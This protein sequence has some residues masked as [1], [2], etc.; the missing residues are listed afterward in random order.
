MQEEDLDSQNGSATVMLFLGSLPA[1][2]RAKDVKELNLDIET[3]PGDTELGVQWDV[4]EDT[5]SFRTAMKAQPI[6]RRGIL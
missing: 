6:T 2:E 5:L 3:L 4:Q 1:E